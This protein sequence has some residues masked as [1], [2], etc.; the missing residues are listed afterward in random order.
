[1]P[2]LL[3][4][5]LACPPTDTVSD[6]GTGPTGTTGDSDSAPTVVEGDICDHLGLGRRDLVEDLEPIQELDALVPAFV[7]NTTEGEWDLREHWTGCESFLFLQDEPAQNRGWPTPVWDRDHA[8]F[9]ETLPLNTHVFFASLD[10]KSDDR[11]A[12][13]E[14][15]KEEL[16]DAMTYMDEER[17]AWLADKLHYVTDRGYSVADPMGDAFKSPGWGSA[18]DRFQRFRYIGSY[19]DWERYDSSYGWFEPNLAMVTNDARYYNFEAE[20]DDWMAVEDATVVP[21]F[22]GEEVRGSTTVTVEL[23]D[24]ETLA[25]FDTLTLDCTQECVGDGEYG[26]CPA[27]DY[28]AYLYRCSE[29][30]GDNAYADT[31]CQEAVAEVSGLC[32]VDGV[33]TKTPCTEDADCVTKAEE[34][35]SCVGHEPAIAADT[36]PG[37]CVDPLGEVTDVTHTCNVDGSGYDELSCG[38]STEIGRWITT[39]HREGR[40]VYDISA[41]LPLLSDGGEQTFRYDTSGPYEVLADL[42]FSNQGKAERPQETVYLFSGGTMNSTY[43]DGREPVEVDIPAQA[44][45]VELATV[46]SQHGADGNNCGEFCDLCHH[47]TFDG[48]EGDSVVHCFPEAT[49]P[50]DCMERVD[51]GTV[52]NQYGTWW[53][54]RAGWCPGKEVPTVMVDVT[55]QVTPGQTASIQ[56]AGLTP[57]GNAY[58]GS[59]TIRMRSWLVVSY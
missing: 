22:V 39:Y 37:Q 43:N 15:L 50:T 12:I 21:V 38:C 20:R 57:Q 5:L 25:G 45:K 56:Y 35:V 26:D 2:P 46:I 1:M 42:R 17:Q 18:V 8:D 41:M 24:A 52:P 27:W 3:L 19:A 36:L 13:L 34:V 16:D 11:T 30:V 49:T 59:A 53:Y 55:D 40:W 23:P 32:T 7:I 31:P 47:F 14:A 29:P 44:T 9:L 10:S 33:E 51:E 54:G 58:D 48:D 4:L 6:S 28:M